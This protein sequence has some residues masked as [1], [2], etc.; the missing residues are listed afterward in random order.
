MSASACPRLRRFGAKK[1]EVLEGSGTIGHAI[2]IVAC[3]R[4]SD[5]VNWWREGKY[6]NGIYVKGMCM[7]FG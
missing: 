5:K 2:G 6:G 4:D 3:T 7:S 1:D